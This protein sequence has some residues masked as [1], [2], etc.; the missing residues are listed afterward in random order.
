MTT[1]WDIAIL[2]GGPG[3]YVAALRAAQLGARVVLIEEKE[4]GGVCLN[5]GCIP[6]K[7][8][9]RSAEVLR[10]FQ[11]AKSFG[12]KLEGSVSPDWRAMQARKGRVVK[13][14]V[15]G[16]EM[17]LS[18]AG[19]ELIHGRGRLSSA[20]SLQVTTA[21]DVQDVKA[22]NV[23]IATGSRPVQLPLPGM[24]LSGVIDS[25]GAL[26][27]EDL[28][29]RLLI[30]GGGVIGC[31][32]A[33]IYSALGTRVTVVE[34]LDRLLPLMDSDLGKA[35][36]PVMSKRKV[37]V[38]LDSR[39]TRVDPIEGALSVSV[40]THKGDESI[41]VDKVLVAVGRRP[42][43][44]NIGLE[45]AG[46][47]VEKSG[48]RVD[49]HCRTNLPT[50]FAIG[51]VSG[52]SQL[53]HVAS[54]M[55]EVAVENALGHE[56]SY[57]LKTNPCCVYTDPEIASVGLSEDEAREAGYTVRVGTF[58]LSANGKALTY[59]ERTGFVKVVGEERYGEVLGLHIFAPHASDLIHEGA[60]ALALEAT[61]DEFVATIHGHPT[62]A[63]AVREAMLE[64][65]DGALHLP[66]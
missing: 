20:S 40:S 43:V 19:V 60:L 44:E 38:L 17:L 49:A 24:E 64:L 18:K 66:H 22:R 65:R 42:N 45:A 56:A 28:P 48:I 52:V 29:D 7:A 55:G 58:P 21:E 32:F 5:V 15:R 16:V 10:Q 6:T 25:T 33:E 8:L 11:R 2:G 9:L 47:R 36:A 26:N 51:D 31:E 23:V 54:M 61:V 37:R 13:Q 50:V 41:E 1:E 4:L 35:L 3:G 14:L 59:G 34:M 62:Q 30:I 12:I 63:E 46:V 27:L 53:A 39:V 57:D